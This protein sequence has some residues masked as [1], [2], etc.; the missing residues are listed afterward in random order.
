LKVGDELFTDSPD[1]EVDEKMQFRF[2]V[3]LSEPQIVEAKSLLELLIELSGTVEGV[4]AAVA[5][6]LA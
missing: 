5:P 3:A 1:A 4:I 6:E 2:E